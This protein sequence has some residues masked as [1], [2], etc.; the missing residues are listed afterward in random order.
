MLLASIAS[1][2]DRHVQKEVLKEIR[3]YD[4]QRVRFDGAI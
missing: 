3:Q 2:F 1:V 4:Q